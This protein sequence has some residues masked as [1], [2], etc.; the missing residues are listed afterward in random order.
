M[1]LDAKKWAY[2]LQKSSFASPP[3]RPPI[4]IPGVS[5]ATI[6]SQHCFRSSKSKPPWTMQNRFC[7]SGYRC[8]TMHRSSHLTERSI[9]SLILT[10]SGEVVAITSSNCM[11]ISDPIEFCKDMECSG[12]R[13]LELVSSLIWADNS[14]ENIH[15]WAIVR[16]K[17][18][19]TLF[20]NS[21]KFKQRNHL[22]P[23]IRY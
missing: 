12:V 1:Y 17:K 23:A 7:F 4:A 9:A 5:R 2:T 8:A 20:G 22:K 11:I 10:W 13:S 3:E 15:R 19:N 16:A 18:S 6:S 21:C 14:S